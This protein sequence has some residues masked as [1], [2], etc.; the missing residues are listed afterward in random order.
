MTTVAPPSAEA[1]LAFLAK[2]QPLFAEGD[3][4]ATYKFALLS[5]LADLAVE[6]G[7]DDGAGL[8]LSLHQIAECFIRM[9][10]RHAAPY[11]AE[12]AAAATG[13]LVQNEGTQAA[14]V[15]AL[16]DFRQRTG[17]STLAQA[18]QSPEYRNLSRRIAS[19]VSAQP[20]NFLQNFGGVTQPFLYER[21][22]RG[23]IRLLP[24][25]PYCLRRFH[26]LVQRLSQMHWVEHIKANKRNRPFL[27]EGDDLEV[28][29]FGTSRRAL[30]LIADGLRKLEGE[31]CFYCR[32]R[33]LAVDI[34][35]FVPFALYG[36]DLAH[37]FV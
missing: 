35:H 29:L 2:I 7:V 6:L 34:D 21:D 19:T 8:R 20:L 15:S 37:N 23:F 12:G 5:A 26:P 1:Q 3:F 33:M 24:G 22:G 32:Q 9:Y 36:R 18:R 16:C 4:T 25:A 30:T 14:V 28:F 17:A 13:I 10:W 31:T 27:G 11:S